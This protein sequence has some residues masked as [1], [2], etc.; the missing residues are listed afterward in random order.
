MRRLA[1]GAALLVAAGL[2]FGCL[3]GAG[4]TG[5]IE[6]AVQRALDDVTTTVGVDGSSVTVIGPKGQRWEAN[7]GVADRGAARVTGETRFAVASITKMFTAATALRLAEQGVVD[8]DAELD[9]AGL[10]RETTLRD[11]LG[12]SAGL[13][14]ESLHEGGPWNESDFAALASR[15]RVCPPRTCNAYSDLGFVGVGLALQRATGKRFADLLKAEVL[16]PMGLT[17]TTLVEDAAETSDVAMLDRHD[18]PGPPPPGAAVP[19]GTWSAGA[20]AASSAELARFGRALFD[21][22]LL[23]KTSLSAMQNV[24]ASQVLPCT[25]RCVRN[26]GLGLQRT[27]YG[28]HLAWGHE[29]SS[30]A[31]LAHFPDERVTVAVLT[32]RRDSGGRILHAVMNA[33]PG[34]EDRGDI[35]TIDADGSGRRRI[36]RHR[37]LD[38]GPSWSPDGRRIVFGSLRDGNPELYVANADGSAVRRLTV[39]DGE[40]GAA[41]W[42]PDGASI[43][44]AS[45]RAGSLDIYLVRADGTGIR[46]LTSDPADE[47]LPA[48]SPDGRQ[49]VFNTRAAPSA[50]RRIGVVAADGTSQRVLAA[51]ADSWSASWSPDGT[52]I[53][54]VRGG[55]GIWSMPAAGGR[56]HRVSPAGANDRWPVWGP[57]GRIAFVLRGDVWTMASDGTDRLQVTHTADEEEFAASWSPD[58]ETLVFTTDAA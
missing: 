18:E 29:G 47:E 14:Y 36:I 8:L 4:D 30:G 6:A 46:R 13:P 39:E 5:K 55:G 1:R 31:V 35:Y 43:V 42:S 19:V 27:R 10:A 12:H 51:P 49:I 52:A 15:R 45:D 50:P 37:L 54:F 57:H 17:R 21:G 25:D 41:R 28:G 44:F 32:T 3:S 9:L 53:S 48:F 56:A 34:L 26:Y 7:S 58:G 16:G 40:D 33:I 23:G 38:G 2:S 20:V 24:S 11:L 22:K